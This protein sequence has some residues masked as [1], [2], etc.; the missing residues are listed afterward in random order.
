MGKAPALAEAFFDSVFSIADWVELLRNAD[1]VYFVIV[2]WFGGLTR[3]FAGF[4]AG[5]VRRDRKGKGP[6][7][8][9]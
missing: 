6:G 7:S 9:W 3:V 1:V 4:F 8:V 5:D 2:R